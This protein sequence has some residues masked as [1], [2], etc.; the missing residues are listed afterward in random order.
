MFSGG[1]VGVS[2]RV[3]VVYGGI[4]TIL[5]AETG[6]EAWLR[7]SALRSQDAKQ[8]ARFQLRRCCSVTPWCSRPRSRNCCSVWRRMSG[9]TLRADVGAPRAN[10][11]I[12]GTLAQFH[13]LAP[14]LN[15]P[16][17]L[18]GDGY[19]LKSARIQGLDCL[20]DCGRD[21]SRRALRSVRVAEQDGAGGERQC[22]R[23]SAA[24]LC[25]DPMGQSVGQ[26]QWPNRTRI[27]RPIDI[28]CRWQGARGPDS[29][30]RSTRAC[31]PRSESMAARSTM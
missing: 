20:V 6:A 3:F 9:R 15:P 11:I 8:Y 13:A 1:G 28:L 16:P 25:S 30:R 29:R 31:W 12:L 18:R 17:D 4:I 5:H 22:D 19:W 7:Y 14:G 10:S 26:P 2:T 24:A 27:R 23:R 21:G